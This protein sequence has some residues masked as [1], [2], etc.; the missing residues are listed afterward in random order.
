MSDDV[1]WGPWIEHDGMS[2]P[3]LGLVAQVEYADG[4][5][6]TRLFDGRPFNKE[7]AQSLRLRYKGPLYGHSWFWDRPGTCVPAV[8][9]RIREPRAV[10]DLITIAANPFAPPPVIHPEGPV[11]QPERV[12]A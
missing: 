10:R 9:Y 11:R 3:V 4:L 8:R 7:P 6:A 12:P 2:W 1:E 5:V